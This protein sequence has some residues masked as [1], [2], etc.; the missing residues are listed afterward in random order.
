MNVNKFDQTP[1]TDAAA[2]GMFDQ[3]SGLEIKTGRINPLKK[4]SR[5]RP[6]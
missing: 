6:T 1:W 2:S 4:K 3:R 5:T